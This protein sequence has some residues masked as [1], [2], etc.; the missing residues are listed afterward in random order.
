MNLNRDLMRGCAILLLALA[1]ERAWGEEDNAAAKPLLGCWKEEKSGEV[2]RF[3]KEKV[4]IGVG[5]HLTI[6]HARYEAGKVELDFMG[7]K[8]EYAFSVKDGLLTLQSGKESSTCRKLD[9][10]PPEVNPQP[11]AL[12]AAPKLEDGEVAKIQADLAQRVE[13]DQKARNEMIKAMQGKPPEP[14]DEKAQALQQKLGLEMAQI[15]ADNTSHL[16]ELVQRVGWIDA[17]RFGAKT[18]NA[19]FLLVQHSM[20]LSLML[21]ALPEIEKDVKAKVIGGDAY[22]L[23]YDRLQMY[24]GEKQKYGTQVLSD[25]NK[26][27]KVYDLQDPAKVDEYRKEMGLMPLAD[28]L[29]LI[30]STYGGK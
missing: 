4:Y 12:P 23:L 24:L 5:T 14:G 8:L 20:K 9:T 19:A 15:D 11:L 3:E 27:W 30:K 26:D 25:N 29:K 2:Y 6:G 1:A 7:Q 16:V 10:V 21:A 28:Y 17:T 22:A 18:A 13:V